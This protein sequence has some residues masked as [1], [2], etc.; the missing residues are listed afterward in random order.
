M[1]TIRGQRP[2]QFKNRNAVRT[3]LLSLLALAFGAIVAWGIQTMMDNQ[4]R[5]AAAAEARAKLRI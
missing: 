4:E 3:G 5:D 1:A 2:T